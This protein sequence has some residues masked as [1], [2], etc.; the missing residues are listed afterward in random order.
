MKKTTSSFYDILGISSA[1]ICLIHC[2]IFPIL[3]I[4]PLGISHNPIIDLVFA[5][6]GLFA[7]LKITKKSNLLVSSILIVSMCLIW[8]SILTDIFLE[9]HL[10]LIYFG[11][12]GM[13]TGH[14]INYKFHRKQ[15]H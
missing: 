15:K 13:I 11:G 3:T 14:L 1:S 5:S 12:I 6:I 8:I 2:L 9:I 4:L 7:I 10:D